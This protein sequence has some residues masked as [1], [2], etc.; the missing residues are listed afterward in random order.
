MVAKLFN[1]AVLNRERDAFEAWDFC[2]SSF[3]SDKGAPVRAFDDV[4]LG[5]VGLLG[6]GALG[7]AV[8]Y[9]LLVSRARAE[10]VVIDPQSFDNPNLETCILAESPAVNL[11]M[12]KAVFLAG[13]LNRGGVKAKAEP[14][15]ILEGDDLLAEA[16]DAFVCGVDNAETR[17]ILDGT[18]TGAL[19]NAGLGDSK[20]DAGFV[21]WTRHGESGVRLSEV[22]TPV[23]A[24]RDEGINGAVVPKEFRE[25]CS[26]MAYEGVSLNIPFAA[27]AA[28]SLLVAGLHHQARGE[29]SVCNHLQFDLFGKQARFTRRLCG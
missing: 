22:Y 8:G 15:R 1:R 4:D 14:R 24:G 23:S 7:S 19:L 29:A 2:L 18:N 28:G 25:A 9:V 6:A 3:T 13:V 21:L 26:R 11:P 12:K 16:W 27:L 10:V 17:R 5:R 20:D